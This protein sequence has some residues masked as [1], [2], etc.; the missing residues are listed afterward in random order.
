MNT[1]EKL[2]V[3]GIFNSIVYLF[4]E[5]IYRLYFQTIQHSY[6]QHHEDL[7][8]EK[9][10]KDSHSGFYVDVGAYD[11]VRFSNTKRFYDKGWNGINIEPDNQSYSKFVDE[12]PKDINLNVGV[13]VSSEKLEYYKFSTQT[14]STFSKEEAQNYIK[15]GYKLEGTLL[16]EVLPLSEILKKH[17]SA[18]KISFFSIDTEGFDLK[19]LESNDWNL[20]RPELI[21]IESAKH[22]IDSTGSRAQDIDTYLSQIRYSKVYDN[23]LNSIYRSN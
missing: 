12:R 18:K 11:P 19:V 4:S 20:F 10:L 14:L 5:L 21:C 8:I 1:L 6:S 9:L 7:V 13:G 17:C 3:Y 22:T 2:K 23:G 15:Q 16:I